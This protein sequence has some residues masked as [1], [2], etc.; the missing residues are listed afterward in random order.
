MIRYRCVF[1]SFSFLRRS[2]NLPVCRMISRHTKRSSKIATFL[3]IAAAWTLVIYTQYAKWVTSSKTSIVNGL[4]LL[5][6][7]QSEGHL[8]LYSTWFC[9]HGWSANAN[10][11]CPGE[12][13]STNTLILQTWSYSVRVSPFCVKWPWILMLT[14]TVDVLHTVSVKF[15]YFK[16]AV[17]GI[18]TYRKWR[19]VS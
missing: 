14:V 11:F 6:M 13:P 19:E 18:P 2:L 3:S 4:S 16:V 5:V 10:D 12:T 17:L 1:W 7:T 15:L 9:L 8:S